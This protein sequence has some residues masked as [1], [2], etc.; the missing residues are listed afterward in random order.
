MSARRPAFVVLHIKSLAHPA[1]ASRR[2][3]LISIRD[4]TATCTRN[5]YISTNQARRQGFEMVR[6]NLH[7]DLQKISY[8]LLNCSTHA[9]DTSRRASRMRVGHAETDETWGAQ[10]V[11]GSLRLYQD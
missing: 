4:L 11:L 5:V 8:T 7:F 9:D 2:E 1:R 6:S 10:Q 3:T